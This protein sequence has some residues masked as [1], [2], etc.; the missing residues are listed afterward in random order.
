[1][2]VTIEK[3]EM[4]NAV[5][6]TISGR[7]ISDADLQPWLDEMNQLKQDQYI[8]C[9]LSGLSYCNSTGLN[10]FIRLLTR[11]RKNGGDCKLVSLQPAVAKLF[12]IS[13]LNEIFNCLP[14]LEEAVTNN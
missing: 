3:K 5:V 4:E 8:I 9:D 6:L 12:E 10:F 7:M 14:S 2:S 1:M 13:K 11:A